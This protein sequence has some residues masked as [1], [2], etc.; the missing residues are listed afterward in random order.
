[1]TSRPTPSKY[2][3]RVDGF[4]ENPQ[5]AHLFGRLIWL[6]YS[7]SGP[8]GR[9]YLIRSANML[10]ASSSLS[11]P[12]RVSLMAKAEVPPFF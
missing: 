12:G 11:S 3:F 7:P 4:Q 5:S 10:P 1:M 6:G 8:F 9:R 2:A